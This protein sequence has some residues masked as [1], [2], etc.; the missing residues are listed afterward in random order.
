MNI[1]ISWSGDLSKNV[2][3][4]LKDFLKKVIQATKPFVSSEDIA[5]GAPWFNELMS[6]L[7]ESSFGIVCLT[8]DNIEQPWLLFESGAIA[9]T[10]ENTES[11]VSTLLIG[12]LSN[13]DLSPPLSLFQS[14]IFNDRDDMLKLLTTINNLL[15]SGKLEQKNLE[16][17][18]DT[19]WESFKQKFDKALSSTPVSEEQIE[20]KT[21]RQFLEE[22]LAMT[23]QS[24]KVFSSIEAFLIPRGIDPE[25]GIRP[26]GIRPPKAALSEGIT[27]REAI[28]TIRATKATNGLGLLPENSDETTEED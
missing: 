23:R 25:A 24:A 7:N 26:P 12:D 17:T 13:L 28:R 18:F 16:E 11:H 9:K 5:K 14:T 4:L 22:I 8:P 1:F 2:A 15:E 6:Q 10:F 19:W 3:I 20:Q 21:D 27:Y